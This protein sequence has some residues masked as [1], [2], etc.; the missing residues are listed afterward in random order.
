MA[1]TEAQKR[2]SAKY[3]QNNIASLA[4]R[5]KIEQA[6]AFKEYCAKIDKTSNAVLREYVLECIGEREDDKIMTW[7]SDEQIERRIRRKL[8]KFGLKLHK[9][10]TKSFNGKTLYQVFE[11]D[12]DPK[13][14][15]DNDDYKCF[16]LDELLYYIE[17]LEA[18]EA[19]KNG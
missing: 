8:D 16:T 17:E 1:P 19:D 6:E 10:R 18:N 7:L 13:D 9:L 12:D 4:C 5:V 3:Q 11:I 15:A 14:F 2:A